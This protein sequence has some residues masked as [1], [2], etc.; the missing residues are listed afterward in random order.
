MKVAVVTPTIASEH[1]KQCLDSVSKQT[2]KNLTHYVFVDGK[3]H[4]I[5]VQLETLKQEKVKTII[6]EE[7]VGKGWYGHRVYAACSFLVNADIICYLDEDNWI[8]PN[9]V[10]SLVEVIRKGNDWAHSLRNIYNKDGKYLCQDNCES[11]GKWPVYF[12]DHTY[13]IDT[14][15][16]AVKRDVA[17]CVGHSW[18]GQWG[19]DRQFFHTLKKHFPKFDCNR[20]HTLNYRLDGNEN[21]V[22][23]EFF[24]KGNE[25]TRK[26]YDDYPW[27]KPIEVVERVIGPGIVLVE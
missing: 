26:K 23:E 24:T 11:L 10:E 22:K 4:H 6:L 1:L 16:F 18:Y 12:D 2:Y 20:L 7:N 17:V 14:S 3:D 5:D 15:C 27:T 25:V 13:H 8:E 21:S 19:A 9:H